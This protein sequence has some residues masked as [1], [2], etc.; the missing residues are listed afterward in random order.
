METCAYT[1]IH[2]QP[3]TMLDTHFSQRTPYFIVIHLWDKAGNYLLAS[4]YDHMKCIMG[5][6]GIDNDDT[7]SQN[8]TSNIA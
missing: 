4:Q 8:T 1:N 2:N 5:E 6:S 7:M 3:A